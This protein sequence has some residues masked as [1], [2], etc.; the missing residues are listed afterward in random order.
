MQTVTTDQAEF[1]NRFE[2]KVTDTLKEFQQL[3]IEQMRKGEIEARAKLADA[4]KAVNAKRDAMK[5]RLRSAR[6]ASR[7]AWSDAKA[8]VE[9]AWDELTE[10]V[11]DARDSFEGVEDAE[12]EEDS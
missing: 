9:S 2:E 1:T 4:K 11:S 6:K 3:E 10:A 5:K 8:G 7:D 12:E